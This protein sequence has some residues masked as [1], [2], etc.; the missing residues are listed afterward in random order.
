MAF[1]FCQDYLRLVNITTSRMGY[2]F[3]EIMNMQLGE[4]VVFIP[5]RDRFIDPIRNAY[6]HTLENPTKDILGQ[7]IDLYSDNVRL[8][9][10]AY[11]VDENK[12]RLIYSRV[13]NELIDKGQI[14]TMDV[15]RFMD[16][17]L[18]AYEYFSHTFMNL[19]RWNI[20]S[21]RQIIDIHTKEFGEMFK[22][23]ASTLNGSVH[24]IIDLNKFKE[25]SVT[26]NKDAKICK[27]H[28]IEQQRFY[29]LDMEGS[30]KHYA[31]VSTGYED[32]DIPDL[33]I[34]EFLAGVKVLPPDEVKEYDLV[35]VV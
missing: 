19:N 31:T 18:T 2:K 10:A 13:N 14:P 17:E 4:N 8:L 9:G 29:D 15:I 20:S 26:K 32:D 30:L 5:M 7:A 22:C 35:L 25:A 24:C 1:G 16:F 6:V 27:G 23:S 3:S 33:I 11:I 21:V 12:I 34:N 28:M